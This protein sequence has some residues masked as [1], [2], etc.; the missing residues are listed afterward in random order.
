MYLFVYA[1]FC[2]IV[3]FVFVFLFA[4]LL[5]VLFCYYFEIEGKIKVLAHTSLRKTVKFKTVQKMRSILENIAKKRNLDTSVPAT[6]YP[7]TWADF[8]AEVFSFSSPSPS[9]S[10]SPPSPP[11]TQIMHREEVHYCEHLEEE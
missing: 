8:S 10:P 2:F 6:W 5:L 3:V 11:L 7:V 9:P 4:V 1:C